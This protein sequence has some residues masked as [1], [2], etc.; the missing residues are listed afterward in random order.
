VR[1]TSYGGILFSYADNKMFALSND[2]NITIHCGQTSISTATT[3][4]LDAWN[5][6]ILADERDAGRLHSYHFG[7]NSGLVCETFDV[8]CPDLMD[9]S[10]RLSLGS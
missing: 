10:G 7:P 1:P 5:Q 8:N 4:T 2:S 6:I 9:V 3:S